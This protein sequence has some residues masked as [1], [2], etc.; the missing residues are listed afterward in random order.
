MAMKTTFVIKQN[1]KNKVR[2]FIRCTIH[3]L[4]YYGG[5]FSI[6]RWIK[7]RKGQQLT[8]VTF[9]R[10]GGE[11]NSNSVYSLPTSFMSKSNFEHII[12]FFRKKYSVISIADYLDHYRLHKKLPSNALIIT[13][14][15]GYK[16][17]FEN[18][19][20]IFEKY[21]LP[22]TIFLTSSYIDNNKRF[23][24]D[25]LYSLCK[26]CDSQTSMDNLPEDIYTEYLQDTLSS[27]FAI[28]RKH[29][30]NLIISMI[31]VL[32]DYDS[33]KIKLVTKDLSSRLH[34]DLSYFEKNNK[35]LSWRDIDEL[36]AIGITFGSHSHSHLFFNNSLAESKITEQIQKSKRMLEDKLK[37]EINTFA[38]PGGKL[39]E[40]VKTFVRKAGY[41]IALTQNPGINSCEEDPFALKRINLWNGSVNGLG[42]RFSKSL[43]AMRLIKK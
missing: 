36:Q 41:V 25:Y 13:F 5:M 16:D 10:I 15:D 34:G 2:K 18:G 33:A 43:L 39:T 32:Q 14:D 21:D 42:G 1:I 3:T 19:L 27:I 35:M 6:L 23:W 9:H 29:R 38:Y 17:I 24:W 31:T 11:D 20:S 40:K 37:C 30:D 4:A 22:V 26:H 8:I 12:K 28:D 7:A